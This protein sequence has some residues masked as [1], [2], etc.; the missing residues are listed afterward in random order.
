[1]G[2][3]GLLCVAGSEP[4]WQ[5]EVAVALWPWPPVSLEVVRGLM[6]YLFL[7][8]S[9]CPFLCRRGTPGGLDDFVG[10]G[11]RGGRLV[12]LDVTCYRGARPSSYIF[13]YMKTRKFTYNIFK[14]TC[15]NCVSFPPES[16]LWRCLLPVQ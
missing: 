5:G 14:I 11:R 3:D 15:K 10:L 2:L 9:L 16:A 1:M 13:G 7:S 12:S 4:R 8:P 6:L